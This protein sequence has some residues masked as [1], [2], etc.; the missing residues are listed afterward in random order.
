MKPKL[1][2]SIPTYGY[3]NSV[4]ANIS[5][6]LE[7][8]RQ[9]IEIVVV[10]NDASGTQ[11]KKQM[12]EIHDKRFHYYQN[13]CNIGRANNI[14]K[15]VERAEADFV[16]LMSSDDELYLDSIGELIG[17]IDQF[18]NLALIM[19]TIVTDLGGQAY[20]KIAAGR[21]EK[22]F[23]VLNVL[24]FLGN[25]LPFVI[26]KK[27]IKCAQLYGLEETYMQN[28]LALTVANSGDLVVLD[29]IIGMQVDNMSDR[30][31]GTIEIFENGT[32]LSTWNT[33]GCYYGPYNRIEQLK[34]E[35]DIIN[36][37]Q[38]RMDKKLKIVIK[39]LKK[40]LHFQINHI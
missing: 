5:R 40:Y 2:I 16:L 37:Y 35:L 6:L 3:P 13:E 15:A 39:I 31:G 9:D 20:A 33:G 24:P 4:T 18:S 19:G 22:G 34:A 10:D 11:I 1:A 27:Y 32:G 21:Y 29:R 28:R 8:K 30:Y 7:C 38:M 14:V 25:L 26:N 12:L 36:Q 17:V 23:Q